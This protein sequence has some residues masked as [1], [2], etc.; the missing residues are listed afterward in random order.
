MEHPSRRS[1]LK[2]ALLVGGGLGLGV[3]SAQNQHVTQATGDVH[4][5]VQDTL[6]LEVLDS[7][8]PK[9]VEMVKNSVV[10]VEGPT[11]HGS[12]F[13]LAPGYIL[14]NHHVTKEN[15]YTVETE[16]IVLP[17][18][19]PILPP[20]IKDIRDP[21][22]KV[23]WFHGDDREKPQEFRAAP[24]M[25]GNGYHADH[26]DMSLLRLPP[27]VK[28]P[29]RAMPV[30]F[31]T[32]TVGRTVIVMGN[33]IDLTGH[34]T[35]G[36][37]TKALILTD[38]DPDWKGVPFVGTDAGINPGNSGGAMFMP[39]KVRGKDGKPELQVKLVGMSTYSYEK[40]AGMGG[41]IRADYIAF[42]ATTQWGLNL[43]TPEQVEQYK[44]DFPDVQ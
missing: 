43:M 22:Y 27:D 15:A 19:S 11:S 4:Q 9:A 13:L 28:L 5:E 16:P 7:D 20:P 18:P 44:K 6:D 30:S 8:F 31:G 26:K 24:V 36:R 23:S 3:L 12:G 32:P 29:E 2:S 42:I 17:F 25:L 1:F 40:G 37:V 35:Y 33:P 34:V 14:T 41:G 10:K 21:N 39:E 38:D